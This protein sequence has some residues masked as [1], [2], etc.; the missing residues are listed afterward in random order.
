MTAQEV[1]DFWFLPPADPD[2][3][4][5]RDI[6]LFPDMKATM[7]GIIIERNG[8]H[9]A[10]IDLAGMDVVSVSFNGALDQDPS[11]NFA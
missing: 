8:T 7:P 6:A 3:G 11:L 4:K 1:L 10:T 2:Y 5:P 9:F